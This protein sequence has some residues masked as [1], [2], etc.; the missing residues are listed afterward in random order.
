MPNFAIGEVLDRARE[1]NGLKSDYQLCKAF[2]L[3]PNSV[4]HWRHGRAL[5]DEK[6]CRIL[7][8][9]AQVDP[10]V[11][12]AQVQA[13]RSKTEDARTMWQAIAERLQMAAH[14][15]AAAI[16]AVVIAMGFVA[17]DARAA[18]AGDVHASE[19]VDSKVY[20]SHLVGWALLFAALAW[21]VSRFDPGFTPCF[22][23]AK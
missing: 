16:F 22:V 21:L 18:S 5:P 1:L 15:A 7:A 14:G 12:T 10:L 20:T 3:A 8:E 2:D 6:S 9:A 23:P 4:S 13:Q 19:S 17:G 11:L